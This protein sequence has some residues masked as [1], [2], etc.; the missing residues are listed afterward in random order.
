[1][2]GIIHTPYDTIE[3]LRRN[4]RD[5]YKDCHSVLKELLQNADDAGAT[6]LHIAWLPS[7]QSAEHPLLHG[8]L[9]M[10]VNNGPFR[11][12]DSYAIHLAGTGSK[13]HD[14]RKIGKF[15][16][17]L[18]SVFHLCEAFFYISDPHGDQEEAD[19][20]LKEF[21][22]TGVLNPWYGARYS[23][24]DVFPSQDQARLR[25]I[26]T[27]LIGEPITSWFGI[28]LPLRRE[29]H[30]RQTD[31]DDPAEWA[32]EPK[33]YGDA[34][35]GGQVRP[36]DDIFS[37]RRVASLRQ[38][39]PLMSS[40][41]KVRFWCADSAGSAPDLF[42]SVTR[43]SVRHDSWRKMAVQRIPLAGIIQVEGDGAELQQTYAGVQ[44]LLASPELAGLTA[45]SDWP[46]MDSQTDAGRKRAPAA[47]KQHVSVVVMEQH[48]DGSL[49]VDRAVFLPLGDPPHPECQGSG[50]HS[51]ELMLHGYFFVDAGRLGVDFAANG[52]KPTVRQEWN[53]R[54]YQG[55]TLPLLLPALAAYAEA[56]ADQADACARL[57]LLTS[58]LTHRDCHL[59]RDHSSHICRDASW[60]F[61]LLAGRGQWVS[62]PKE[63]PL[64]LLPGGE[65]TDPSLPFAV[66]PALDGLAEGVALS[67]ADLPYMATKTCDGTPVELADAL[68]ASTPL[69]EVVENEAHLDYLCRFCTQ[70]RNQSS[71]GHLPAIGEMVRR[72]LAEVPLAELRKRQDQVTVLVGLLPPSKLLPVPFKTDLVR[73]SERV[74]HALLGQKTDILPVPNIFLDPTAP[75][76]RSV[77]TTDTRA[78]LQ[79]LSVLR[80]AGAQEDAFHTLLGQAMLSVLSSWRPGAQYLLDEFGDLPLFYTRDFSSDRRMPLS[81]R[82]L[83][84]ER[85]RGTLFARSATLCR[86]LQSCLAD[87]SVLFVTQKELVGL[88]ADAIGP[89]PDCDA[90]GCAA[91]LA[92]EPDLVASAQPR[93]ELLRELLRI[94]GDEN[95][96]SL[97]RALRYLLHAARGN[98]DKNL[99]LYADGDGP[100]CELARCLLNSFSNEW[101]MIDR[102]LID[103]TPSQASRLGLQ[104][105]SPRA[106]SSLAQMVDTSA[107]DCVTV[108]QRIQWR[109]QIIREWPDEALDTLRALPIYARE[110]GTFTR[111]TEQTFIR[112]DLPA[113]PAS[114]FREFVLI[115]DPSGMI[116]TRDL[117][118]TLSPDNVLGKVL[119]LPDCHRHWRFILAG[120]PHPVS[121]DLRRSL[122]RSR[123]LPTCDGE[124]CSPSTLICRDGLQPFI[125]QMTASG[126]SVYHKDEVPEEL[127]A[128]ARWRLVEELTPRGEELYRCLGN[129]LKGDTAFA[130]GSDAVSEASLSEF[131]NT[132]EGADG[133]EAM[134]AAAMFRVLQESGTGGTSWIARHLL[135]SVR[136]PLDVTRAKQVLNYVA[137]KHEASGVSGKRRLLDLYNVYLREATA[138]PDFGCV[139]PDI[140]LLNKEHCWSTASALTVTGHNVAHTHLLHPTHAAAMQVDTAGS[141]ADDVNDRRLRDNAIS[142]QEF[143]DDALSC[144]STVL[145]SYLCRWR[146]DD[147]PEDA[148]AAVVAMLGDQDGYP[149]LY[150]ELRD[151]RT[152]SAM[153]S[154]FEWHVTG[155]GWGLS[156]LMAKQRFCIT[157][158]DASTVEAVNVLG[159]RFL[160]NVSSQITSLFDGFDGRTYFPLPGD[161]RCYLI[162]LR[163]VDPDQLSTDEKLAILGNTVQAV[164]SLIHRQSDDDF[165]TI[166]HQITHVGQLDIE[167]AQEMILE[168]SAMLLETQ[169]SIRHSSPLKELFSRWHNVRQQ[170]KTATNDGE[171][172]AAATERARVIEALRKLL[173]SDGSTQAFLLEEIRKRLDASSYHV[174]SVPFELFQN[175]D[176]AV[177]ELE[178]LC[179][180]A[181]SLKRARP[182]QLRETFLIDV[183]ANDGEAALRVLHW[184]RGIN[185]YRI[186]ATDGR[187]L[188]FDRDLERMLVMQGSGKDYESDDKRRTGKFGLG[189]KSVFFACESPR[190]LSGSRSRFMVLAGVYPERLPEADEKRLEGLLGQCGDTAHRGTVI[191]LPLRQGVE[192]GNCL[193]RFRSLAG[194][195]VVFARRIRHCAVGNASGQDL[196]VAWAPRMVIP[197][198]EAGKVF[199]AP[200]RE[201][202]AV[203]FRLHDDGYA[204]VF[205]PIDG[206]GFCDSGEQILPEIWVTTPTTH[207]GRGPLMV[208]GDFDLNPGRTQLR[209]TTR[210]EQLADEMGQ[211]LGE[212]LCALFR[213]G[214]TNWDQIRGDLGCH[215]A[216][217]EMFWA[218]LWQVTAEYADPGGTSDVLHRILFGSEHS[219]VRRLVRQHQA[220][221][222][223]LP[224][225]YDC[226]TSLPDIQWRI[227]GALADPDTWEAAS[228][229]LWLADHIHPGTIV[230]PVVANVIDC[231]LREE[232][233]DVS[234][235]SIVDGSLRACA[236]VEADTAE[237]LGRL[238]SPERLRNMESDRRWSKEISDL[239]EHLG[240]LSFN[241]SDKGAAKARLL[242]IGHSQDADRREEARRAAFAP[243]ERVLSSQYSG[244]A[245][246]FFLACRGDMRA[247][248]REM[249]TWI[250]E[251]DDAAQRRAAL[252]YLEQGEQSFRVEQELSDL[253][254]NYANCW[255]DDSDA[256]KDAL[257]DDPNRQ[258]VVM[259]KLDKGEEYAQQHSASSSV[260]G[261]NIPAS[262]P[263]RAVLTDVYSWWN[264]QRS[265]IVAY[266]D[267]IVYPGGQFPPLRFSSSSEALEKDV[268]VRRP[269]LTLFMLAA[270]HRIG[271]GAQYRSRGFFD[272]CVERG[273]LDALAGSTDDPHE[274]FQVMDDYL[275]SLQSHAKYFHWMNQFLAYYQIARWLP[276]YA[277]AF[278]AVTRPRV[279]L[280]ELRSIQDI[281]NLRTSHIFAGS[282]GF[283]APPCSRMLGLGSHFVLR[284]TLRARLL[285]DDAYKPAQEL[286]ALAFVPS[287]RTRQVF[288]QM[289]SGGDSR[290]RSDADVLLGE[291]TSKE[292]AAKTMRSALRRHLG[293]RAIFEGY[294]DIPVLALTW[295][296]YR[297]TLSQVLGHEV[298]LG[299]VDPLAFLDD[300]SQSED[301]TE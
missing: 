241:T 280:D 204:S 243:P 221:P 264:E 68:L 231:F 51:F 286:E 238:L 134:P 71:E 33:Y 290:D 99:P 262:R 35:D 282:T 175:G 153:R 36:P 250:L 186:G 292:D 146:A 32:I 74:Y 234:L 127:T 50:S 272:L 128:N 249:A 224:G 274:W 154:L 246:D 226:L 167:I 83:Q 269:W 296:K 2:P 149:A 225:P 105:C 4:L 97:R 75:G 101:R 139:L 91:L 178:V 265:D 27:S 141:N 298:T 267:Q 285:Q 148:L 189:F 136:A 288:A 245:L 210:N 219:G 13:G 61:R 110:D 237:E 15:G 87:A 106:I 220:L 157:P 281:A 107:T 63:L 263:P 180:D 168:S 104:Q 251:A 192:H 177:V 218:S 242:L 82:Q 278:E 120:I 293:D 144:S 7:L 229:C 244:S 182:H 67:F 261:E 160:A 47:V 94:W 158:A 100:W 109:D 211:S 11:Y 108:G 184:G 77:S 126:R 268:D 254:P 49:R 56:I 152:L 170:T 137:A 44:E 171:R 62:V 103:V 89:I 42:A 135:P 240:T 69:T 232:L 122:R 239:R 203:V 123:W 143:D 248:A 138:S 255:L 119:E 187:H 276:S 124:R 253:K 155:P 270:M 172:E 196:S 193:E 201:Q 215:Q 228:Q 299:E 279:K 208:N 130:V 5:R 179:R 289:L 258:A 129:S 191:E 235:R 80:P 214:S 151:S 41:E 96:P 6:Q 20:T 39:L 200:H 12:R 166:W 159:E 66:F 53:R 121:D 85:D 40:V 10:I 114:I 156:E 256:L 283:D 163:Q 90:G 173:Q 79:A 291:Q 16:L 227:R 52:E 9:L 161:E 86:K 213:A 301:Q 78:F 84:V 23:A 21:G 295:P 181:D 284:E 24:W 57:R 133:G 185:Q 59:W 140:R 54:L 169:L 118:P 113:P 202:D 294:Y 25:E 198:V 73:E 273:W 142:G 60:C 93:L 277:R 30:C 1:M 43:R 145:K 271:W 58:L 37:G 81:A 116:H 125:T 297:T 64:V 112:G 102:Q 65:A 188:G 131:I 195:L 206:T 34:D 247:T 115:N 111:I 22:R 76:T 46:R 209:R 190:V 26:C 176:D 207:T 199:S 132:F 233:Q 14:E 95:S 38:M 252:E 31:T 275:D 197:G 29:D 230:A 48:G 287:G 70:L 236:W 147:V 55:G 8:P 3:D 92:N 194:Y 17:G 212:L 72:L 45:R 19:D 260:S 300:S 18:K 165:T 117:A 164:R 223:C 259:G 88:L 183:H 98:A 217:T 205:M 174:A 28:C 222:T 266:H 162:R 216:S 257:P 150:E